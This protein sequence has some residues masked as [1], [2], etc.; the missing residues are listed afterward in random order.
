MFDNPL[1]APSVEPYER[2]IA[3]WQLPTVR[4]S[5]PPTLRRQHSR[6][7]LRPFGEFMV[8]DE[9]HGVG[10][11]SQR[12]SPPYRAMPQRKNTAAV[13]GPA[14]AKSFV[15][16]KG[17]RKND[18]VNI[19]SSKTIQQHTTQRMYKQASKRQTIYIQHRSKA[20]RAS[21]PTHKP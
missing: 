4:K 16:A 10:S 8:Y 11:Q 18:N 3:D 6:A 14:T 17:K 5:S 19:Y 9:S 1:L 2:D 21:K 13:K 15:S 20:E 7:L 12:S